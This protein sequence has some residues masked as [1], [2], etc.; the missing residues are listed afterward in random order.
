MSDVAQTARVYARSVRRKRDV[1]RAI[2][3]TLLLIPAVAA[4]LV[5]M[6]YPI[7]ETFRLSLMNYSGLN[8]PV[9]SGLEN[10]IKLFTNEEFQAGLLHVFE[11]A[12]FSVLVQVP[13]AFL[14]A[15]YLNAYRNKVTG[16][17]R[18][19]YY[20]ASI[21]PSAIVSMIGRFIFSP[22]NG[23]I[24]TLAVALKLKFL[25][26][27]DF[28]G[29]PN[30]AFWTVFTVATWTYT[31]FYIVYLMA[32]IEQIP[33]EIREAAELDGASG[34]TYGWYIVIPI[35]SYPLRIITVLCIVGSMKV[36]DLP[37]MITAGGP[38]N[39]TKTLGIIMYNRGFVDWQYGKASAVGVVIFLCSLIFTIAQFSWQRRG[40]EIS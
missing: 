40:G 33:M 39:A 13:L 10:Y 19:V 18:A 15:F 22:K 25:Q 8:K 20:M 17:L 16:S 32:R 35:I 7:E 12:F 11:W 14:I 34:W 24:P 28:L 30:I 36:F 29:D 6:Y 3:I 26:R 2:F 37:F 31:G 9:Y 1:N 23:V 4:L 38:G 27:I 21:L 5:F